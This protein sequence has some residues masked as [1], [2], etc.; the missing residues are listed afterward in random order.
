M[1][2]T[3]I[4]VRYSETDMMGIVYHANYFPWFEV[5]RTE[6]VESLGVSYA[7]AEAEGLLMPLNECGCKFIKSAVYGDTVLIETRVTVL[8][9]ARCRYD[10][11]AY[12]EAD[13]TLLAEGYTSHAFTDKSLCPL[14]LKKKFPHIYK[15][16]EELRG[17]AE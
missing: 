5:A 12:R 2:K 3:R 6:L 9:A 16:L 11:K 8:T 10:Y 13:G 1:Q 14:N 17:A 7:E 4:T 15:V